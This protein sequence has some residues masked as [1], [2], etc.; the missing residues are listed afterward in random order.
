MGTTDFNGSGYNSSIVSIGVSVYEADHIG[1]V[2]SINA[3]VGAGGS[4]SFEVSSGGTG[5]VNPQIFVSE[6]SYDNLSITGISRVGLGATTDTGIG[7][8]VS[9]DIGA[10]STTGIGSTYFEMK[11]FKILN[12]GYGFK[13]GDVF[14]PVGLVTDYRLTSPISQLQFKVLETYNDNFAVFQYGE[15]DYI[16]SI[17]NYQD[18]M[19]VRFP[20]FYQGDLISF[21]S[22][23]DEI[24]D[25]KLQNL[26][27]VILN[28]I[29]QDPGSSYTFEGG[30]SFVFK[31][32]PKPEDN[33]DIYFYRGTRG[34]DDRLVTNIIPSLEVGDTVQVY[35]NNSIPVTKTQE[36]RVIFDISKSDLIETNP[37]VGDGINEIDLS[38]YPG[39]NKKTD[40]IVNGQNV[41]KTRDSILSQVYPIAKIIKDVSDDDTSIS[42]DNALFFGYDD[43]DGA[44]Y[45][46]ESLIID[47]KDFASANVTTTIGVGG[48]ISA[49]TITDPGSGYVPSSTVD[50]KFMSPIKL[51]VVLE[52]ASAAKYFNWRNPILCNNIKS[53]VWLCVSS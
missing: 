7:F 40:R 45:N 17:K 20:L 37:Y 28:G 26:L 18:G 52:Y 38:H 16:D 8:K 2:A 50:I 35:K 41:F 24:S 44:P 12:N 51:E 43:I 3:V 47:H 15:F 10:G 23:S 11:N 19:R 53:W 14:T 49:V 48:T 31:E 46:F 27:V 5:Y 6:P 42:V 25:E 1:D 4:L 9:V 34:T 39:Q 13:I 30:T 33:I 21:E 36:K 32:P 29:I 22:G